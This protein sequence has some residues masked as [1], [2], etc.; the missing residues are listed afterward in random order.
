MWVIN[1]NLGFS[2]QLLHKCFTY[3]TR[4]TRRNTSLFLENNELSGSIM[5]RMRKNITNLTRCLSLWIQTR[6]NIIETKI[7]YSNVIPMCTLMVKENLL[8]YSSSLHILYVLLQ[9]N[10]DIISLNH[11]LMYVAETINYLYMM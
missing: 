11:Y 10:V 1:M 4:K 7:S 5:W 9:C 2:L 3:L 6:R 8:M